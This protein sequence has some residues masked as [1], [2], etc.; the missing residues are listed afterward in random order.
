MRCGKQRGRGDGAGGRRGGG[1]G[2]AVAIAACGGRGEEPLPLVL[3]ANRQVKQLSAADFPVPVAAIERIRIP[4]SF[5]VRSANHRRD[6]AATMR[7]R[8][9]GVDLGRLPRD[10]AGGASGADGTG[11]AG[12]ADGT[13]GA[14]RAG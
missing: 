3:A 2:L 4:A 10:A 6:L 11:R 7:N 9:V 12:G 14:G 13:G 5:S 1:G 8:L